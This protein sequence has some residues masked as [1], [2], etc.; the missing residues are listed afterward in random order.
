MQRHL[1]QAIPAVRPQSDHLAIKGSSVAA[2]I[3]EG[4]STSRTDSAI[5]NQSYAAKS[6]SAPCLS[7]D[8]FQSDS[9]TSTCRAYGAVPLNP[10]GLEFLSAILVHEP[11]SSQAAT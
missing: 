5:S 3:P 2:E 8:P 10:I 7:I 9:L 6:N 1:P 4:H 11:I